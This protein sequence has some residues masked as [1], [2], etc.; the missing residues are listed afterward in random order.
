MDIKQCIFCNM[1]F[2]SS[3]GKICGN[4][5]I[6]LDLDMD[7]IRDYLEQPENAGKYMGVDEIA[8]D[9]D[10][11]KKRILHLLKENRLTIINLKDD[12][13][14]PCEMCGRPISYGRI[15][16]KCKNTLVS[17][18][19]YNKTRN[20]KPEAAKLYSEKRDGVMHVRQPRDT[21]G[22]KK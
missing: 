10:I 16:D 13:G 21:R 4:C 7:K 1:P 15:C 8:K 22:K 19:S 3:G 12:D 14:L 20:D 11:P 2:Q 18:L 6:Q 5:L 17:E 9:T